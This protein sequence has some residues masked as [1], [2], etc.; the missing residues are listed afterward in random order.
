MILI[1]EI[2]VLIQEIYDITPQKSP[3]QVVLE[4]FFNL[5]NSPNHHQFLIDML[6]DHNM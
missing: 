5:D 4:E 6:E 3:C 1:Q 2:Y